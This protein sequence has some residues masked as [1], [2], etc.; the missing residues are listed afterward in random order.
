MGRSRDTDDAP[1]KTELLSDAA[2]RN[3]KPHPNRT[4]DN[5][6]DGGGLWLVVTRTRKRWRFIGSLYSKQIKIWLGD[7]PAL[8]LAKARK[9]AAK[10]REMVAEGKNPATEKQIT[11]ELE[12]QALG[13]T[14]AV[15]AE[16]WLNEYARDKGIKPETRERIESQIRKHILPHYGTWPVSQLNEAILR[17][18]VD[19]LKEQGYK[20]T[21]ARVLQH[22]ANVMRHAKRTSRVS[23]D[24][25]TSLTGT[26][27]ILPVIRAKPKAALELP[28]IPE[29]LQR[30]DQQDYLDII[31]L[32]LK[33]AL[34]TGARSSEIRYARWHEFDLDNGTWLIPPEREPVEGVKF[35]RRGEKN[36]RPRLIFLSAQAIKV[37]RQVEMLN[38][39]RTF[40]FTGHRIGSPVSNTGVNLAIRAMGFDTGTEQCL[41]GFRT[42]M[43]SALNEACRFNADAIER[44]IGH[45][46]KSDKGDV[47]APS[48]KAIRD[49]YNRNAQYA[50][51]RKAMMAW[52]A[53]WLD[54]MRASGRY[55]EPCDFNAT[56]ANVVELSHQ[57]A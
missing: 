40:V 13:A 53:D 38:G 48:A 56:P 33:F 36:E 21:A 7:Y 6:R 32:F 44:H 23:I 30:L 4:E 45:A 49:L 15:V 8:T 52:W 17:R 37:M 57:A 12:R 42:L 19:Q 39:K 16:E 5:L 24:P 25:T 51:Q 22:I 1:R 41:H 34:L 20:Q 18:P 31:V 26:G 27:G 14:F 10:C 28:R 46:A 3:A 50:R 54:A 9:E 29:L 47:V 55:I 43:T 2:C 11:K 35:S